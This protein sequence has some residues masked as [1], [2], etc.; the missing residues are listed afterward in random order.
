MDPNVKKVVVLFAEED[1]GYV[2]KVI[3][4]EDSDSSDSNP[5]SVKMDIKPSVPFTE[6]QVRAFL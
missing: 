2:R 3:E 5:N 1:G 6:E 4:I